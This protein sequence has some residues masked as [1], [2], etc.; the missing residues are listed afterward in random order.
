MNTDTLV[1]FLVSTG[2]LAALLALAISGL[3]YL[4][5][6]LDMKK[7]ELLKNLS[8]AAILTAVD[9]ASD[10]IWDVVMQLAQETADGLK[11]KSADGKLTADE[12]IMLR[13]TA[14]SRVITLMGENAYHLLNDYTD[15]VEKWIYTKID[16]VAR[17][18]KIPPAPE[19]PVI[20]TTGEPSEISKGFGVP[21]DTGNTKPV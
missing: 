20:I 3:Q 18:T 4:K 11:A 2:L 6:Y 5:S 9:K 14:Y 17:E 16:A 8:N 19:I 15:D 10:A 21:V 12:I 1:G 7:N 13:D